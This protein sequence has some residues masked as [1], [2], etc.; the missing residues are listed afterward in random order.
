MGSLVSIK[1]Y[2]DDFEVEFD[3]IPAVEVSKTLDERQKKIISGLSSVEKQ[4]EMNKQ[5]IDEINSQIDKLTN[6]ADGIDYMVAVG[7]GIIAGAIDIFFVGE[8]SLEGANQWGNDKVNSF[9]VKVAK[10]QGYDGEDL[11]GAILYLAEKKKHKSGAKSGFH[12]SSDSVTSS[13]GGGVQHHLR[14]FAHHP[15]VVGLIFSMLTQFTGKAYG[16]DTDG[17]FLVVEVK[18]KEFIGKDIPQKLLYG[19]IYWVFHMVSDMAGSGDTLSGGTGLPGPILSLLKELSVLP[20]FK[21]IKVN[22]MEFSKWISKLFNGTLLGKKDENGKLI[23]LKFDLR[24]EIGI[25]HELGK[26]ALPVIINECIVRGFYFIRRF[27]MEIKEKKVGSLRDFDRINWQNVLPFKNRTVIRMLTISTGTFTAIDMA[28]AAIQSAVKSGGFG[29]ALLS[30]MV[31]RVNFIGIGRFAIA[32]GTDVG[33]GVKKGRLRNERIKLYEEQIALTG[34]KVFY[35]Q[36]DMWISAESAGE[37]IEKAYSMMEKTT[38]YFTQSMQEIADNLNRISEYVP[39]IQRKNPGLL[40]DI[41]EIL[42]WE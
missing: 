23:P 32:V 36:A 25:A 18:N 17:M 12:L 7:S 38:V 31:L 30:N 39:S 8:F 37:T 42:K 2:Y 15:T 5:K 21:N 4:I 11:D 33:M 16:T 27:C 28:D 13:F 9:V 20:F 3:V 19:I 22:D 1:N 24:T 6:H 29:P 10:T 41:D 14:D 34:A 26:Q 35:K 40:D